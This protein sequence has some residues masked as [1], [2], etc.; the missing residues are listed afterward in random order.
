MLLQN[1]L[2]SISSW[3]MYHFFAVKCIFYFFLI[4]WT[5]KNQCS[6]HSNN[7]ETWNNI[8]NCNYTRYNTLGAL[9]SS[10]LFS[11]QSSC[12]ST[13]SSSSHFISRFSKTPSRNQL[14]DSICKFECCEKT[15]ENYTEVWI[16]VWQIMFLEKHH[17]LGGPS[18]WY[19]FTKHSLSSNK[20][21]PRS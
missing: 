14:E 11:S 13:M 2:S 19:K 7:N 4:T 15:K 1:Y 10:S 8:N 21:A 20:S 5:Y 6:L 17:S 12:T 3:T 18:E 9:T 16:K